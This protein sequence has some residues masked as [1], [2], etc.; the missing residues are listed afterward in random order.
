MAAW[1]AS[2]WRTR[3]GC[4]LTKAFSG[5]SIGKKWMFGDKTVDAG[6]DAGRAHAVHIAVLGDQIRQHA[7]IRNAARIGLVRRIAADAL[8][9]ITLRVVFPRLVE[10]GGVDAR[11]LR[12]EAVAERQEIALVLP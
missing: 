6:I 9:I 8:Q 1:M 5:V 10:A 12:H 4:A 11:M 2:Q 3:F 7:Q